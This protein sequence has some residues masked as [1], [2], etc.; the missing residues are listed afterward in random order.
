MMVMIRGRSDDGSYVA[1]LS[2]VASDG[3]SHSSIMV[4]NRLGDI[5]ERATCYGIETAYV[6]FDDEDE[7]DD[8]EYCKARCLHRVT[9]VD[10]I[11]YEIGTSYI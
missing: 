7:G 9:G 3:G 6:S 4:A 2:W 8:V 11:C 10:F 1:R 5:L